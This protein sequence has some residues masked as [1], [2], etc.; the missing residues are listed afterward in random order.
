[1][2]VK[3]LFKICLLT[4]LNKKF[5][6]NYLNYLSYLVGP[7]LLFIT[8]LTRLL[9]LRGTWSMLCWGRFCHYCR[10]VS[11][12]ATVLSCPISGVTLLWSISHTC[13]I[14]IRLSPEIEQA[15]VKLQCPLVLT[16]PLQYGAA[17][18]HAMKENLGRLLLQTYAK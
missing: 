5:W 4:I 3:V 18:C 1:M 15:S 13:S 8:P 9:I 6:N 16:M 10:T 17:L 11:K 12:S 7:P 14:C 2:N